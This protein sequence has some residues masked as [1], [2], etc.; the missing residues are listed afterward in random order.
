MAAERESYLVNRRK[1]P[2]TGKKWAGKLSPFF[3]ERWNERF[4]L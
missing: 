1:K 3:N 2:A 4:V